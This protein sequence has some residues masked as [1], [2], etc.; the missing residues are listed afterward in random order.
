M[1]RYCSSQHHLLQQSLPLPG[2][3]QEQEPR[4]SLQLAAG[5]AAPLLL[6]ESKTTNRHSNNDPAIRSGWQ[7]GAFLTLS[8]RHGELH[9]EVF[10]VPPTSV[11][12]GARFLLLR[13]WSRLAARHDL[14]PEK[15]AD[16]KLDKLLPNVSRG[17]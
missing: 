4:E 15:K 14:L 12:P 10:L 11:Y 17:F 3:L 5:K 9:A 6:E 8:S 2:L 16:R 1:C 13:R 7:L